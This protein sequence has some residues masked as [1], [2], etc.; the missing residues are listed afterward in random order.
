MC[1]LFD[2]KLFLFFT[3][4]VLI[5]EKK[6]YKMIVKC[7]KLIFIDIVFEIVLLFLKLKLSSYA[8]LSCFLS[9]FISKYH[10]IWVIAFI[11]R[12]I[13]LNNKNMCK[14]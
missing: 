14:L 2:N 12:S 5:K 8:T 3:I 13:T 11:I 10:F 4:N 7:K 9:L 1:L 6:R